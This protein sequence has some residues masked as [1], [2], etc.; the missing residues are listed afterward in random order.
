MCGVSAKGHSERKP[1]VIRIFAPRPV[2]PD[3]VSFRVDAET[4]ICVVELERIPHETLGEIYGADSL[5]ALQIAV[6]IEPI[7]ALER[8]RSSCESASANL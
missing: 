8:Q 1:L 5:Q 2:D 7:R 6:Y 4:A 3:S